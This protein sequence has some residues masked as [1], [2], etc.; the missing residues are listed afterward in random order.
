[1]TRKIG[2]ALLC[3]GI[4]GAVASALWSCGGTGG[5]LQPGGG[6]Q[7][8]ST[9]CEGE[10]SCL[11]LQVDDRFLDRP[12]GEESI[13]GFLAT[14]TNADGSP[15]E[16]QQIC[17]FLEV[18][19]AARII[20]PAGGCGITDSQ[21]HVSGRLQSTGERSG[22]IAFFARATT[23]GLEVQQV[24]RFHGGCLLDLSI[25]E[26]TRTVPQGESVLLEACILC[27]D[28]IVPPE[29]TIQFSGCGACDT[30]PDVV[31]TDNGCAETTVI[32]ENTGGGSVG[33]TI[34]AQVVAGENTGEADSISLTMQGAGTPTPAPTNT[35]A[36]TATPTPTPTPTIP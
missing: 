30:E 28:G 1:M 7:F 6:S 31:T 20:E 11:T 36:P 9:V 34:T 23:R 14:L 25:A 35:N 22:S 18:P 27:S 15:S 21:G 4:S 5:S 3:L 24:L 19:D 2:V 10:Q 33:V 26:G 13:T 17:F 12:P 32:N 16:G 8:V 29:A